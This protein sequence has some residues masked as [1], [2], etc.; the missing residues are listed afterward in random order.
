MGPLNERLRELRGA[1]M[2]VDV[3]RCNSGAVL[4]LRKVLQF[5]CGNTV[6]CETLKDA[7]SIAFGGPQRVKVRL[8]RHG[9]MDACLVLVGSIVC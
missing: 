5:V 9:F 7:R 4:E 1:K 8:R 2:L 6:V 3:V